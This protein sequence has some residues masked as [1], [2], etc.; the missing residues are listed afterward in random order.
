MTF[1]NGFLTARTHGIALV[2]LACV[3]TGTAAAA[4]G[5]A[6]ASGNSATGAAAETQIQDVVVTARRREENAQDVPVP[7][8]IIS[9]ATLEQ[10]GI[11]SPR[12][13]NSLAPNLVI[14]E[15]NP[16]QTNVGIR[17]IG[18]TSLLSD[19][20][21][22]SVG[23][24][25]DGV[26]LGRPGEFSYDFKDIDQIT[27]QRGPQGTLYGR[28][29]TGGAIN[30]SSRLPSFVPEATGEMSLGN[31]FL[32]AVNTSASGP[33]VGDIL[34]LRLTAYDTERDGTIKNIT[35]GGSNNAESR[36][37]LRAQALYVP[38]DNFSFRLIGSYRRQDENQSDYL[39]YAFQPAAPGKT[40]PFLQGVS[41]VAPGYRP[42]ANLFGRVT[43]DDAP[44]QDRTHDALLSGEAN[45][46]FGGGYK[47]T[48]I[49][50]Y[51]NWY[52]RPNND[53]DVSALPVSA[54]TGNVNKVQQISQE[55]RVASPSGRTI[56]Y[57]S[58]LYYYKEA[59]NGL[60]RTYNET[61]AWA[62]NTTLAGLHGSAATNAALSA[63]MNNF[64]AFTTNKPKT[65][66]YAAFGQATWHIDERMALT[67]GLRDTYERKEQFINT[68]YG[69]NVGLVGCAVN[70]GAS[71]TSLGVSGLTQAKATS[72][73]ATLPGSTQFS[74]V[75]NSPSALLSLS[76]KVA[77]D[78]MPYVTLSRS[79]KSPGVN[80]SLLTAAQQ[81]GGLAYA[82]NTEKANNLEAGVKSEFLDKRLLFN[83]DAFWDLVTNYQ[84][85]AV[86]FLTNG[87]TK[88]WLSN[89][90][91]IRSRGLEVESAY[92]PFPGM[93]LS[94]NGSFTDAIYQSFHNAPCS[95]EQSASSAGCVS[96][97]LTGARVANAPR[98]IGNVAAE[99]SHA[100]VPDILGYAG[101]EYAYRTSA[102]LTTDNSAYARAGAYGVTNLRVGAR[103]GDGRFDLSLWARNA[104]NTNYIQNVNEGTGTFTAYVGDPVTVGAT[105][106]VKF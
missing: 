78:V 18:N 6:Q 86:L 59:V 31:Y 51:Q 4:D 35:V 88:Q 41:L 72:A 61:D 101:V 26:Y 103:T 38:T 21:T 12:E 67:G 82:T 56:E 97:N 34:A 73:I 102:F 70:G 54:F 99:Y 57:V 69:G 8:S 93:K 20:L 7:M 32:R 16:R 77:D 100:L 39:I 65:N 62:F 29:T 105:L 60:S 33:V 85:N 83:A 50:A 17:G 52:F 80:V 15:T 49:T 24:Y 36:F 75:T 28:N 64:D 53:G 9:G 79:D 37:G 68:Y 13:L 95:P 22:S 66:S 25:E 3:T 45:W 84:Q 98:W 2:A 71:C 43:D 42:P 74:V 106:R 30:V 89:V 10:N 27:V 90:G 14:T 96:Q 94:A 63:A 55:L 104:L 1:R 19:G 5:P 48:S 40:N 91:A 76:Y 23:V 81:A 46:T 47:L 92:L 11:D 44:Q 87:S 58:G